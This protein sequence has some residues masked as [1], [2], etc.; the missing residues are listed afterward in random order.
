MLQYL[1]V[2]KSYGS[3]STEVR[4]VTDVSLTVQRGEFVAV[5]GPSGCGKSTLLHL[6][7]ALEQPSAGRVIVDGN[8][9]ADLSPAQQAELRRNDVGYVFQ[10]LNLI[11]ALTALENVM[12]PLELDGT[13]SKQARKIARAAL[14]QVGLDQHLDRYPDDFSGG[15]RQRI[16]IARALIGDRRLL[17][18]DE[19][20]GALDTVNGDQ[21]VELLAGLARDRGVSVVM[22][23]HD[24]RFAS[25]ADRVIFLRDG[26]V[27]DESAPAFDDSSIR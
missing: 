2:V 11:P 26:R 4:A 12:L 8:D 5:M 6:A 19:P 25:W 3:G 15:Q 17:L 24:P 9:L 1:D 18:A 14:E 20:T 16:A 22:V 21:V 23:T 27:V 7:G 13:P 10:S